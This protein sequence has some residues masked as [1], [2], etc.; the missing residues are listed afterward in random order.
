M[1][2]DLRQLAYAVIINGERILLIRSC[3]LK[4]FTMIKGHWRVIYLADVDLRYD[5]ACRH[6]PVEVCAHF[7]ALTGG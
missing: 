6:R 2:V 4:I 5:V 1:L 3:H 7:L